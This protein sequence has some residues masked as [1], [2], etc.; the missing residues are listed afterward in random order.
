MSKYSD[1]LGGLLKAAQ[2]IAGPAHA[3]NTVLACLSKYSSEVWVTSS[4]LS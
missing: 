2:Q 1:M 4:F 3:K